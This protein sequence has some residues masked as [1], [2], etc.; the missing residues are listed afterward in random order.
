MHR[1]T[2]SFLFGSIAILQLLLFSNSFATTYYVRTGGNDANNG[3]SWATAWRTPNN[4]NGKIA[5]GD[6]VLFGAGRYRDS[7][8]VPPTGGTYSRRTVY[9]CSTLTS[10]T[11]GQAVISGGVLVTGWTV[12]SGSIYRAAVSGCT[13]P[14][15]VENDYLLQPVDDLT[16]VDRPGRYVYTGGYLYVWPLAGS[17]PSALTYEMSCRDG[18]VAI[19]GDQYDHVLFFGLDFRVAFSSVVSFTASSGGMADSVIFSNCNLSRSSHG[20]G[21]NAGVVKSQQCYSNGDWGE[22]NAFVACSL[23]YCN[24]TSLSTG[25]HTGSGFIFYSARNT[26]IDSCVITHVY[27][28]GIA[29]KMG[30]YTNSTG[31]N[32]RNNVIKNC[33]IDGSLSA[34]GSVWGRVPMDQGIWVGNKAEYD[35]IYGN[36]IMNCANFAID[37]HTSS[38]SFD[39]PILGHIFVANNTF[40][41]C[42]QQIIICPAMDLGYNEIKYNVGF[43]TSFYK[44]I[45]FHVMGGEAP[46]ESPPTEYYWRSNYGGVIDSN[47]WYTGA[48]AFV[49]EFT[50]N[51]GYSGTSWTAWRNAG[52]D[53]RSVNSNPGFVNPAGMDF[54]R[55]LAGQEMNLTYG[56]RVWTRF[57]AWQP[58]GTSCTVPSVPGLTSPADGLSGLSE[59]VL[60][61]WAD[62][63]GASSYQIQI[64]N[65]S[66]FSSPITDQIVTSSNYSAT[67]LT[68]GVSLYWRV[69]A[70]N[71]C[72]PGSWSSTRYFL[73]SCTAAATPSLITPANGAANIA[74][75]VA[76][77]W[78]EVLL[79]T[80]Y[81]IQIDNNSDFSSP[82]IDQ[83]TAPLVSNYSATGLASGLTYYWRVRTQN[84][85]GWGTW[86]SARSFSI[87]ACA[88]PEAAALSSPANG[89]SGLSQ[90]IFFDWLDVA[91]ATSYQ[92]QIDNNS[93]FSS[94]TIDQQTA[95]SAYSAAGLAAGTSYYWRARAQN[96]CGW[97]S[98]SASRSIV[99]AAPDV[100]APTFASIAS[101][102]IGDNSAVITWL[103]NE[104]SSSQINYGTTT[105]YG[106]TTTLNST[107][108][109]SHT[110]T[111][112]GLTPTTIYHYRVRSRDAA[113]NEAVSGDFTFT[114]T[115]ALIDLDNGITP[116]VSSTY[117]GYSTTR[118]T[119]GVLNPFGGT[120]S[121]WS[122]AESSTSP[123]WIE[124][125]FGGSR[126]VKR[127]VVYWA[128]NASQ[129]RWMTSQQFKLQAWGGSAFEDVT[130]VSNPT[131]DSC[132]IITIVPTATTRFRFYQ[133]ANMGPTTY[134]AVIWV[135][136]L[137]LLGMNNTAPS[138]PALSSPATGS[139]MNTQFPTLTIANS[140]DAE[141]N[142]IRYNFQVSIAPSFSSVVAQT[143]DQVIG[144]TDATSWVVT[145]ALTKGTTYYWRA[146]SFDGS[147][148]SSFS[149]VRSFQISPTATSFICGDSDANGLLTISDVVYLINF[150][151][152]GGP[153]PTPLL[154]G[155]ADC[156]GIITVSDTVYLINYIFAGG[157]APCAAC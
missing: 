121:T 90:P 142:A 55:P 12:Y 9:A 123:H 141:G 124:I 136:E 39:D 131:L 153:G 128:W 93:D 41:N 120:T 147:L 19:H 154:S 94:V 6:V 2:R 114:T 73:I 35:S 100:T 27:G 127:V 143:T 16:L 30:N 145:Q 126:V 116:A 122:S 59:P 48:S 8:I 96:S 13:Y 11:R 139:V 14:C 63:S 66:D 29:L 18:V 97:G 36:I 77:D 38:P 37:F 79:A 105:A 81:Q 45:G 40:Y 101:S 17:N 25:P 157:P 22:Y 134:P 21:N 109:S 44:T 20:N 107:L 80:A 144:G 83:Q 51:S 138:V 24:S 71:G 10:A 146:Y 76:I 118:I 129:Q 32:A 112:S 50:P 102:N 85:C 113:G 152:S 99:T 23:S 69:R 95:A 140:V 4:T 125:N 56:G 84:L 28:E 92:V 57:G 60:T 46:M 130:V 132:T 117:P 31:K 78:S 151:F 3:L 54:S 133:P 88:S 82:T 67:G 156:N 86:T 108:V 49:G 103:T 111:L 91:T 155:D 52:F 72:G 15:V 53:V 98:W 75:P 7:Q 34:G 74:L 64:D 43:A 106:L 47:L 70:L 68:V 149:A 87:G 33:I 62:V 89:A 119:D 135:S 148:Y 150:I 115:N 5:A 110:Q 26:T 65:N 61:D 1:S 104:A 58:G 137:A 42:V